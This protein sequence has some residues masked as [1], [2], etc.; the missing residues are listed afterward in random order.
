VSQNLIE[1]AKREGMKKVIVEAII[2]KEGKVL[3]I[4]PLGLGNTFYVFPNEE[5]LEGE[6]VQQALQKAVALKTAMELK[7]VKRYLGHY[8]KEGI[9]HL[10]FVVEVKD[11]YSIENNSSIAFA[12]VEAREGVGYPIRDELREILDLYTK[13]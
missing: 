5:V 6:T 12:W 13:T 2:E 11:P 7:E 4:E 9:R 8:D 10:H 3:L 1:E